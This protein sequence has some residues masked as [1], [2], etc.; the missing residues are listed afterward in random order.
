M[1]IKKD[2]I[3]CKWCGKLIKKIDKERH[4]ENCDLNDGGK[5]EMNCED[6]DNK[7]YN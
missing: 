7:Y 6:I 4:E 1:F 3:R 5:Y 2:E